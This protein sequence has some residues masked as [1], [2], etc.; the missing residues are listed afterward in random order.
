MKQGINTEATPI[1]VALWFAD[2]EQRINAR[3]IM[4][5]IHSQAAK[6]RGR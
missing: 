1:E 2:F 5:P 4:R 3:R 6:R